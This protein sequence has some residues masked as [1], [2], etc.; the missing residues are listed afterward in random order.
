[1]IDTANSRISKA[2]KA[3]RVI[4]NKE[5]IFSLRFDKRDRRRCP[6]II[7][8][9]RRTERVIGRIIFLILSINTIKKDK[10]I[11]VPKGIRWQ[12]ILFIRFNQP[13]IINKIHIGRAN[14][15]VTERCLVAVKM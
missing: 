3:G 4:R 11:G 15:N 2:I 1:M 9:A 7:L 13:K 14:V 8:A 10:A 6:A 5:N 12:N